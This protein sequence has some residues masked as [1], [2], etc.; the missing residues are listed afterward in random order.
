VGIAEFGLAATMIGAVQRFSA[1]I[2][3]NTGAVGALNPRRRDPQ[4]G[5]RANPMEVFPPRCDN[6][7]P[8]PKMPSLCFVTTSNT[9]RCERPQPEPHLSVLGLCQQG[10][11]YQLISNSERIAHDGINFH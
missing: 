9:D 7:R 3:R 6:R 1:A 2:S 5:L 4:I 10:A 8:P 11:F